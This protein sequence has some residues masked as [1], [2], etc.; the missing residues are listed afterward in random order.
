MFFFKRFWGRYTKTNEHQHILKNDFFLY[1]S[2]F[3]KEMIC[4]VRV[5]FF[6]TIVYL[7]LINQQQHQID[8]VMVE[9]HDI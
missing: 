1:V 8:I 3:H 5:C 9:Q 2:V 7:L 4:W 6:F